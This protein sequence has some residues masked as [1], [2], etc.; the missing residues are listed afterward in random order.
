MARAGPHLPSVDCNLTESVDKHALQ[1]N[2]FHDRQSVADSIKVVG[3][4][5]RQKTVYDKV[6]YYELFTF[7]LMTW[8]LFQ[9]SCAS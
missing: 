8:H 9:L 4:Y 6:R 3:R 2:L 7:L 1:W 5:S